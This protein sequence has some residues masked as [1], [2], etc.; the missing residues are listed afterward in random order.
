LSFTAAHIMA[1]LAEQQ[2]KDGILGDIAEIGIHHGKSFLALANA[3]APGER[4]IAIDVFD[5]Q[6]ENVDNSGEGSREAFLR[7][8]ALF[9]PGKSAEIIQES[10]LDLYTA[11]WQRSRAASIRFFSID[12]SH[13]REA[14]V[15]DLKIAEETVKLGG[16]VA[17]D[18]ILS[19]HWLGVVSGVFDYLS[20]GGSLL[21]F[22]MI[23]NKLL[24]TSGQAFT[25]VWLEFL[26]KQYSRAISKSA[27]PFLGHAIEIFDEDPSIV[28][29]R[30]NPEITL[31]AELN[32]LK[33]RYTIVA[34]ENEM[35][36]ADAKQVAA[37]NEML[38]ADAKQLEAWRVFSTS[39]IYAITRAYFRLRGHTPPG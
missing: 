13:T 3:A 22:A 27:V 16:L 11:G 14:T 26:R 28:F 39:K 19:T 7:N 31:A 4:L 20:G 5:D 9:A 21:P 30:A 6:H 10:S 8:M 24:L 33:R 12:G 38:R 32:E 17:V 18:D 29:G 25:T 37:E 15:N 23:P 1:S 34:A 2:T 36:R 35:L